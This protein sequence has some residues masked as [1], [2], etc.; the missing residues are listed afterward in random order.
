MRELNPQS[1]YSTIISLHSQSEKIYRTYY[2]VMECLGDLGGVSG[3]IFWFFGIIM[4]P[5]SH[6]WFMLKVLK[7][8]YVAKTSSNDLFRVDPGSKHLDDTQKEIVGDD[9]NTLKLKQDV[10]SKCIEIKLKPR[11]KVM[12]Y[13]SYSLPFFRMCWSK[14]DKMLKLFEKGTNRIQNE[15]NGF[16]LMQDL[17]DLKTMKKVI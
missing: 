13:L 4:T 1:V 9:I 7:K 16:K 17:R 12:L 15:L 8:M 3:V 14:S 2:T 10:S 11:D 5:L 6:F